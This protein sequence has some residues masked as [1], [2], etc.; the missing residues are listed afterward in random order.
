MWRLNRG[1]THHGSEAVTVCWIAT[2]TTNTDIT[3]GHQIT[4]S[5]WHHITTSHNGITSRHDITTSH[6]DIRL[7]HLI[8][9]RHHTTHCTS[10]PHTVIRHVPSMSRERAWRMANRTAEP[11]PSSSSLW[12]WSCASYL[13]WR[14]QR[15]WRERVFL[16]YASWTPYRMDERK[17]GRRGGSEEGEKNINIG[18]VREKM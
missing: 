3:L 8:T 17:S 11:A 7:R 12:L 4:I 10:Q 1:T 9:S 13:V 18:W 16:A 2:I 15:W 14:G 5:S 6:H